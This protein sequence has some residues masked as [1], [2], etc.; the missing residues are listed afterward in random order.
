MNNDNCS[1]R[2]HSFVKHKT[3]TTNLLNIFTSKLLDQFTNVDYTHTTRYK[4]HRRM[5]YQVA[6]EERKAQQLGIMG[7]ENMTFSNPPAK[8]I[9][10]GWPALGSLDF[11]CIWRSVIRSMENYVAAITL[12]VVELDKSFCGVIDLVACLKTKWWLQQERESHNISLWRFGLCWD[13]G[14]G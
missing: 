8:S 13:T 10:P 7:L 14:V 4:I 3:T 5:R 2:I 1:K 6:S 11:V 9:Q 12:R